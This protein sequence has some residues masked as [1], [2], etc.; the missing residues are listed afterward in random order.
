MSP[1]G[2]GRQDESDLLLL[3]ADDEVDVLQQLVGDADRTLD[4]LAVPAPLGLEAAHG[5]P[6]IGSAFIDVPLSTGSQ[7]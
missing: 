7:C 4:P 3:A 6:N 5:R 1:A 2:Q